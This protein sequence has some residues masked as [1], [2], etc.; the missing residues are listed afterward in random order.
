M[1]GEDRAGISGE[2]RRLDGRKKRVSEKD[3]RKEV[4]EV[5]ER[6]QEGRR[7]QVVER[8]DEAFVSYA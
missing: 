4:P 5:D 7:K 8:K 1:S 3:N 6:N 2:I